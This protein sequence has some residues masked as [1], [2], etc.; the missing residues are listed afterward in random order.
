MAMSLQFGQKHAY[1]KAS[2]FRD[3]AMSIKE[4]IKWQWEGYA[5]YHQSRKNLLIHIVFVPIF[6]ISFVCFGLSVVRFELA[7]ALICLFAMILSFGFQGVGHSKETNASEP[8]TGLKN[9]FV[10]ILAEQFYTFPK[11]VFT[12]KWYRALRGLQS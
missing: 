3:K 11:F 1:N 2:G 12:G 4:I 9:V 5:N 7:S 10:R 8:F 6:I